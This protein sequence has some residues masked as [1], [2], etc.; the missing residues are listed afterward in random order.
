MSKAKENS[1]FTKV[2]EGDL[3]EGEVASKRFGSYSLLLFGGII[4]IS[5]T[6]SLSPL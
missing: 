2:L 5:S 1:N 3:L 4:L 6:I